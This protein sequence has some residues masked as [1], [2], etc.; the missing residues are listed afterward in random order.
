MIN[1][2]TLPVL[3]LACGIASGASAQTKSCSNSKEESHLTVTALPKTKA[4]VGQM[5]A[6]SE[7]EHPY[8]GTFQF[9]SREGQPQEIFTSDVLK[10]IEEKRE[11]DKEVVIVLSE[12]TRVR[13]LSRKTISSPNFEPIKNLY[14]FVTK[15]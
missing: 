3:F 12:N 6:I 2:F 1:K 10:L 5:Q 4:P 13:I 8:G 14:S 15:F 11:E 9:I 7:N